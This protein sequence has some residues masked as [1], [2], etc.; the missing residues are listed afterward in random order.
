MKVRITVAKAQSALLARQKQLRKVREQQIKALS[1]EKVQVL[2]RD[3]AMLQRTIGH[4]Q[5]LL[6]K[7]TAPDYVHTDYAGRAYVRPGS[8]Q[9]HLNTI[10]SM[11]K[12]LALADESVM[13]D[14]KTCSE[15]GVVL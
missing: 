15:I 12:L 3:I 13:L 2:K 7:I 4:K 11:L 5:K 8:V 1:K 9:E 10:E 14:A 6:E